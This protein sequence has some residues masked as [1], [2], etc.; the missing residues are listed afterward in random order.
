M[1]APQDSI[2][3]MP[4]PPLNGGEYFVDNVEFQQLCIMVDSELKAIGL[5]VLLAEE[6]PITAT[7]YHSGM[8]LAQGIEPA[9]VPKNH[10]RFRIMPNRWCEEYFPDGAAAVIRENIAGVNHFELT[11]LGREIAAPFAGLLIDWSLR[12]GVPLLEVFRQSKRDEKMPAPTLARLGLIAVIRAEDEG[13][14]ISEGRLRKRMESQG[15]HTTDRWFHTQMSGL[16]AAKVP[17]L[18]RYS[19]MRYKVEADDNIDCY[20]ELI[21]IIDAVRRLDPEYL[22]KGK[23]LLETIVSTKPDD[24]TKL[25]KQYIKIKDRK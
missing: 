15:V 13:S 6:E 12:S 17:V 14:I 18:A 5:G 9:F 23:T 1:T 25:V 16:M 20:D 2:E 8:V 7:D 11:D 21:E 19:H 10:Q 22:A 4:M 24:V 3:T